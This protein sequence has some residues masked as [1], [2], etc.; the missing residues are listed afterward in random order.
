M[1]GRPDIVIIGDLHLAATADRLP[2]ETA[3]A[4]F[5]SFASWLAEADGGTSSGRRVIL[6][7]DTF[8]L[9][10]VAPAGAGDPRARWEALSASVMDRILDAHPGFPDALR[11]LLTAGV[12]V[13]LVTGNH[14]AALPTPAVRERLLARIG[15]GAAEP[16]IEP[17][18]RYLPGVVYAEHGHQ[19]H[20]LNAFP[21]A[22][23]PDP[24]P[25]S[26]AVPLAARREAGLPFARAAVRRLAGRGRFQGARAAYRRDVLPAYAGQVGLPAAALTAIDRLSDVSGLRIAQRLAR[27]ALGIAPAGA[28]E[29]AGYLGPAVRHIDQALRA[30]GIDVPVLAFG[31]THRP[32][33]T[34][35]DRE[36]GR[37]WYAN[38]GSWARVRPEALRQRLGPTR[39]PFIQI[40]VEPDGRPVPF[41]LAWDAVA[42]TAAPFLD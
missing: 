35:F 33:L 42:G 3:D 13:D 19:Y 15:V 22:L 36:G 14:D 5:S 27:Q 40:S 17:W 37:T 28:V 30:A 32:A 7:G 4:A 26:D 16:S 2:D 10:L 29:G 20:D 25:S 24:D 21:L 8:D 34:P 9:P 18:I 39:R 6:L 23:R 31:H 38:A 12:A 11:A 1:N 41:V